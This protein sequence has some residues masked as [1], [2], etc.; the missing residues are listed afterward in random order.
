MF[1]ITTLLIIIAFAV[2]PD[3][4]YALVILALW[5]AVAAVAIGGFAFLCLVVL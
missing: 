2:A 4:M 3:V 1:L 5:L